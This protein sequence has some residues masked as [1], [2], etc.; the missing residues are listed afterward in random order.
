MARRTSQKRDPN[1]ISKLRVYSA[2]ELKKYIDRCSKPSFD[3]CSNVLLHLERN[4]IDRPLLE[5]MIEF[6]NMP[7][8]KDPTGTGNEEFKWIWVL[9][10]E[11]TFAERF[12]IAPN[13]IEE[14]CRTLDDIHRLFLAIAHRAVHVQS[15][16]VLILFLVF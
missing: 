7:F 16:V 11:C 1:F 8:A 10:E 2:S 6:L 15:R 14:D 12:A 9:M 4:Y 3:R 5:S 13:N